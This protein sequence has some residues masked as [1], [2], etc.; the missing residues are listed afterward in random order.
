VT[1]RSPA[2]TALVLLERQTTVVAEEIFLINRS[3]MCQA[4]SESENP[5][6]LHLG[7]EA[8][9]RYSLDNTKFISEGTLLL[10]ES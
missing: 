7:K 3:R 2:E 5:D 10:D 1:S 8:I 6:R 9:A 4:A